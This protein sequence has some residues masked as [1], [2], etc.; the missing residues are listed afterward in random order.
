M[1][2]RGESESREGECVF[3]KRQ[4]AE[5][6][7]SVRIKIRKEDK[8]RR[9]AAFVQMEGGVQTGE[10]ERGERQKEGEKSAE[11]LQSHRMSPMSEQGTME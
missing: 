4:T 8:E 3:Q 10:K 5:V 1:L 9:K 7:W 6:P 2:R 11:Y